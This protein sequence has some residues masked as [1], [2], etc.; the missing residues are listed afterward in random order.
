MLGEGG[1][2]APT[3]KKVQCDRIILCNLTIYI[4]FIRLVEGAREQGV[5]PWREKG[6]EFVDLA[7]FSYSDKYR[8]TKKLGHVTNTTA[9]SITFKIFL[10]KI[11]NKNLFS[12]SGRGKAIP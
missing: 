12:K 3:E 5:G 8:R 11:W 10:S 2:F 6:T 9:I 7:T 1:G 4:D